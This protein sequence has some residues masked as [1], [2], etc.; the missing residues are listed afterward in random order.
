MGLV[1][2]WGSFTSTVRKAVCVALC[3]IQR[4]FSRSAEPEGTIAVKVFHKDFPCCCE[5]VADK[6]EPDK[7]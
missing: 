5:L 3:A 1:F 4:P 7:P 2:R 6:S